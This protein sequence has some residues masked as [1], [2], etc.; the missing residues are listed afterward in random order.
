M[1]RLNRLEPHLPTSFVPSSN[2]RPSLIHWKVKP[3]IALEDWVQISG[4]LSSRLESSQT[5]SI[6]H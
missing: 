6:R 4:Q 1:K 5:T 3:V 2:N